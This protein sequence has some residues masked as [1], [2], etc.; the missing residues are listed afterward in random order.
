M[1]LKAL[2]PSRVRIKT[3]SKIPIGRE[4]VVPHGQAQLRLIVEHEFL[5]VAFEAGRSA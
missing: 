2:P 5:G 3:P 1:G 4:I